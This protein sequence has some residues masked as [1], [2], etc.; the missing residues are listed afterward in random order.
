MSRSP[1]I[2]TGDGRP[3]SGLDAGSF[4]LNGASAPDL[5]RGDLDAVTRELKGGVIFFRVTIRGPLLKLDDPRGAVTA[6]AELSNALSASR[7]YCIIGRIVRDS[8]ST[9]PAPNQVDILVTDAAGAAIDTAG[10]KI[11][12]IALSAV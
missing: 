9:L 3:S 4:V 7:A 8:D 1:V 10:L 11:N 12:V 6:T 2:Y 5:V